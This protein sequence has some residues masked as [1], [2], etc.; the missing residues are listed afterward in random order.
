MSTHEAS[1]ARLP[2]A[3][4]QRPP[5]DEQIAPAVAHRRSSLPLPHQSPNLTSVG[6]RHSPC[7]SICEALHTQ[8]RMCR[9][10]LEPR[11]QTI[12]VEPPPHGDP[13]PASARATQARSSSTVPT[14]Q[15]HLPTA[16]SHTDPPTHISPPP[17]GQ[18]ADEW[19]RAM[20]RPP[21]ANRVG[22]R[23]SQRRLWAS[24]N[25][26][27]GSAHGDRSHDSPAAAAAAITNL[28]HLEVSP[29][30]RSTQAPSNECVP[31]GHAQT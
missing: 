15:T 14:G 18:P 12:A 16:R 6:R 3:H 9:S 2:A 27:A 8:R 22:S 25:V 29:V 24:Q 31:A 11:A 13:G 20:Q 17:H 10:Q 30:R 4:S 28:L 5:L 1:W 19:S 21:T 23:H 26:V 7:T